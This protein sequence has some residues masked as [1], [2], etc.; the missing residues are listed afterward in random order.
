MW[1]NAL[2]T[3]AFKDGIE[4]AITD[5]GYRAIRIDLQEHSE[6]IIDRI[7]AEIKEARFV[8]ADFT[9]QRG[10]VYFEAGFARGLGLNVIWTCKDDHFNDL[11][12]DVKGFN[13]IEWKAP[14][15]LRERLNARIRAVVGYGPLFDPDVSSP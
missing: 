3:P 1:F 14:A 2:V 10:G 7:I 15:D 13:V 8:I 9:G 11:H 12:F 5:T 4:P 6:S